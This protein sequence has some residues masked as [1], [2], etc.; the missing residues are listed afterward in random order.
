MLH[1]CISNELHL[2][3]SLNIFLIPKTFAV[4]RFLYVV[5]ILLILE[6]KSPPTYASEK[7][8]KKNTWMILHQTLSL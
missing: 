4:V 1:T 6:L 2:Q 7:I 8:K 3:L 5:F